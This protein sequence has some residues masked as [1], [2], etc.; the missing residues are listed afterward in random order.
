MR[1][2]DSAAH[3]GGI[4]SKVFSCPFLWGQVPGHPAD[5]KIQ[6]YLRRHRASTLPKHIHT[7]LL[8]HF[9]SWHLPLVESPDVGDSTLRP[10]SVNWLSLCFQSQTKAYDCF[11]L[12]GSHNLFHQ[13]KVNTVEII[14]KLT[15]EIKQKVIIDP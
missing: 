9:K 2:Q 15:G 7:H 13:T 6:G 1:S 14:C 10:P 8:L 12:S 3:L 4:L 11:P 5:S